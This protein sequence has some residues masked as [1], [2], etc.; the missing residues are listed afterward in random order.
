MRLRNK[1]S[2]VGKVL[3]VFAAVMFGLMFG[4]VGAIFVA[5]AIK[6]IRGS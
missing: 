5:V 2:T 3:D 1:A 4:G 6:I